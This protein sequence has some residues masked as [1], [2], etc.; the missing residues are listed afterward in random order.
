MLGIA[1]IAFIGLVLFVVLLVL[2]LRQHEPVAVARLGERVDAVR[3]E[4]A[5]V[6]ERLTVARAELAS[7]DEVLDPLRVERD[8]VRTERDEAREQRDAAREELERLQGELLIARAEI[9]AAGTR[10]AQLQ[11]ARA[12]AEMALRTARDVTD[13]T[14]APAA[15]RT[16]PDLVAIAVDA[17]DEPGMTGR[18]GPVRPT[19]ALSPRE[20]SHDDE[21]TP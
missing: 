10:L 16:R 3:S 11:A 8:A 2:R 18:S 1:E 13:L 9:D 17:V 14:V 6:E 21:G 5:E 4:L 15:G 12:E 20:P 19:A 7:H